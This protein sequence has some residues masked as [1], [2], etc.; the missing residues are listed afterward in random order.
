MKYNV[1][2]MIDFQVEILIEDSNEIVES[3]EKAVFAVVTNLVEKVVSGDVL[4]PLIPLDPVLQR[5]SYCQMFIE[6]IQREQ[7]GVGLKFGVEEEKLMNIFRERQGRSL[8]RLSQELYTKD[9]HFV[10]ELIQNADDNEYLEDMMAEKPTVAFIVEADKITILNNE[11]GFKE[12]NV[13]ALCDIGKSTK[14]IHRKGY[15]GMHVL[16]LMHVMNIPGPTTQW[17]LGCCK[18]PPHFFCYALNKKKQIISV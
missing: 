2:F 12:Q 1:L 16:F 5:S 18:P 13:K 3:D 17:A 11:K 9:S 10:L 7:F 14:G 15:I 6:N 8:Y 4:E